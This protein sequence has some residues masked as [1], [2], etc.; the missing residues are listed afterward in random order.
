MDGV[1]SPTVIIL[2]GELKESY[3]K[4]TP[5]YDS[6]GSKSKCVEFKYKKRSQSE[7]ET[8]SECDPVYFEKF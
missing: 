2:P 5:S 1:N 7:D 8:S 3:F 4:S 6:E